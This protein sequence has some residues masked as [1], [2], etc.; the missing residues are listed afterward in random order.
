MEKL[1]ETGK[2]KAIG[3]SNF[4]K[5]EMQKLLA[6]TSV[7][8]AVHQMEFHPWLQQHEFSEWHNQK[9][10]HITHYSPFGNQNTT[11]GLK[12]GFGKLIDEPVLAE[13][14]KQYGK[15]AAQVVLGEFIL[16]S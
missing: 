13:I 2:T 5:A 6:K 9:G 14:G 10:I 15:T 16:F 3:V 1:L 8:P 4:S 7:V 11:Y 12:A